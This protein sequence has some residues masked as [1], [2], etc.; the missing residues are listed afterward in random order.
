M[1]RRKFIGTLPLSIGGALAVGVSNSNAQSAP[2]PAPAPPM[3]TNVKTFGATGDGVTDDTLAIQ[4]AISSLEKDSTSRGGV[5]YFPAGQYVCSATLAFTSYSPDG[6]SGNALHNIIVRGDGPV[7]TTLNFSTAS[8][9][10]NGITF[11]AGAHFGIEDIEISQAPGNGI[12]IGMGNDTNTTGSFCLLFAI[13]NV[14]VQQSGGSGLVFTNAFM[15]TISDCWATTSAGAG[16]LFNGFHTSINATRSYASEN[17]G[18]GWSL[19]GL[20]YSSFTA[21]GSDYN[22]WGYAL[23]NIIGVSFN[24]CGAE[25][26]QREGWYLFTD[27][28]TVTGLPTDSQDIHGLIFIS[29]ATYSNSMA[30]TNSYGSHLAANT[31]NYRPIEF[32]MIGNTSSCAIGSNISMVLNASGTPPVPGGPITALDE[33]SY[34]NGSWATSGVVN[35]SPPASS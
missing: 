1:E 3:W 18:I 28:S 7:C 8:S 13:S 29:C 33:L 15:G 20:T 30:G 24:S 16:Y 5:V 26:N 6:A 14:R 9:G 19:N 17:T 4:A 35:R 2:A 31:Q 10:T 22:L 27:S 11:N 21:C 23:S 34:F 12:V 32:K 25:H